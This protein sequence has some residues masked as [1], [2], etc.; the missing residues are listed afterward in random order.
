MAVP[1]FQTI[2][3]PLLRTIADQRE[4]SIRDVIESLAKEFNLTEQDRYLVASNICLIIGLAGQELLLK[5]RV[6]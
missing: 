4:Y 5:K 6:Y 3:L 1:D 2:M